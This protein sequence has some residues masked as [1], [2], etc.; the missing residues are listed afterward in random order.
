MVT[1]NEAGGLYYL[2][3]SLA[4]GNNLDFTKTTQCYVSK[5]T[6]YNVLGHPIDQSLN[7]LKGSLNLG[8][9]SLPPFDVC[10]D[11]KQSRNYFQFNEH[12]TTKLGELVHLDVWGPYRV[13][14]SDDFKF[15]LTIVDDFIRGAWVYLM[16]SKT[17]V[18]YWVCAFF[19]LLKNILMGKSKLLG[20]TMEQNL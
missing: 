8:S 11:A 1:G 13:V 14:N 20:L 12:K 6:W 10:H 5:L 9:E 15:F 2:D 16:K 3:S 17:E 19:N 7:V 4:L 18:F